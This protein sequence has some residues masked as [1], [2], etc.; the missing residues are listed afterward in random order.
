[1][2]GQRAGILAK[3]SDEGLAVGGIEAYPGSA[4][5]LGILVCGENEGE[6]FV[7]VQHYLG[8]CELREHGLQS[9]YFIF[10]TVLWKF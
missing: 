8:P 3:K 7:P 9:H 6:P 10:L 4:P 1:M 5:L 2:V